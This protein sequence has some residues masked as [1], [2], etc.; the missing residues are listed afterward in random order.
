MQETS[1]LGVR[2]RPV[3]RIERPR[4]TLELD[5][6]YGRVTLKVAQGDGISPHYAPEFES[7]KQAAARHQVSVKEVFAAALLAARQRLGED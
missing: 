2:L 3:H 7:C 1:T 6:P 4:A 5:T